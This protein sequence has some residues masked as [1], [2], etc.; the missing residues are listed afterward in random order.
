MKA[1]TRRS[2]IIMTKKVEEEDKGLYKLTIKNIHKNWIIGILA[3]FLVM[4]VAALIASMNA[5]FPILSNYLS[6]TAQLTSIILAIVAIVY[7]FIQTNQSQNQYDMMNRTLQNITHEIVRLQGVRND[8]IGTRQ[9]VDE[10]TNQL[11][12]VIEQSKENFNIIDDKQNLEEELNR[13]SRE[14]EKMKRKND[15]EY[16]KTFSSLSPTSSI[17]IEPMA[18]ALQ[19]LAEK[20]QSM[21]MNDQKNK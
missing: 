9:A 6:N 21:T 8:A 14:L 10:L 3:G 17:T 20:L 5:K 18:T 19:V 1:K 2:V 13:V 12:D 11:F 4:L 15:Q 7:A 16:L